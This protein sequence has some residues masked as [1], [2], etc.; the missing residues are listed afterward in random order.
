M[1]ASPE[2][3]PTPGTAPRKAPT[4]PTLVPAKSPERRYRQV[5]AAI[6]LALIAL[7]G[8]AY[9]WSSK[10]GGGGGAGSGTPTVTVTVGNVRPSLRL[11]GSFGALKSAVLTAPRVLGNRNALNRGGDFNSGG[12]G[13]M[14]GAG[15][16]FNLVLLNLA[17]PGS[18]VK[19]GQVVAQFDAQNQ[20]QRLD[21][22]KDTVVQQDNNIRSLL[23]NLSATKEGEDQN[24]RAAKAAWQESV[25]DLQTAPVISE[26]DAEK[27]K[28]TVEQNEATY[29]Q[30]L[31]E[32]DLLEDSQRAQIRVTELNRNQSDIELQ[33]AEGN[34]EKM[35]VK[36]PMDGIVVMNSV[37][38]NGEFG[39]IREGDQVYAGQPFMTIVDPSSMVLNAT[40]NQ[41]DAERLGLG[42]KAGIRIDAYPDAR[43]TGTVEGIGAMAVVS[44]AR[45]GYVGEIPVR[46]RV[47]GM[48][49]HLIPDLTGS[50]DVRIGEATGMLVPR[51]AVFEDGAKPF[52]YVKAA[53]G[54]ER[55]PVQL[56]AE[57]YISVAIASGV[58]QGDVVALR[59][60]S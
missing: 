32:S 54:W 60:P 19:A 33:R 40:V 18:H 35:T 6:P 1:M 26:I 11:T 21:D 49:P 50:A 9:E 37:I 53:Q 5:W 28:L 2:H 39:Q 31:K 44:T 41:V 46:I 27:N 12:S 8:F 48:D 59:R 17:S 20:K 38:R 52:V 55:V 24:V 45:T 56:G 16:D 13:P 30:L 58:R 42:M 51:A 34:V 15:A 29:K 14:G 57:D 22:Y 25:L 47:E 43:L 4:S 3:A 7:V 23:A 36:A 10:T